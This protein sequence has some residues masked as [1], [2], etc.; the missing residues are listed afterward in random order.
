MSR[1]A[2]NSNLKLQSMHNLI[3]TKGNK[4]KL[5]LR[6]LKAYA[7]LPAKLFSFSLGIK[8]IV[9]KILKKIIL[10][11]KYTHDKGQVFA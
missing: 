6:Y 7:P 1:L 8:V 10:L 3:E 9:R 11:A 4:W 2:I 5:S